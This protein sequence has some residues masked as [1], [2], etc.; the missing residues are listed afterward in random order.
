M[1]NTSERRGEEQKD[2]GLQDSYRLAASNHGRI[3]RNERRERDEER[4]SFA[5]L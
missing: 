5:H 2:L 4:K 1:E 3:V